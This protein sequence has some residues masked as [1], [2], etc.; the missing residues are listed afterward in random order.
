MEREGIDSQAGAFASI[1]SVVED[2]ELGSPRQEFQ[3]C[4]DALGRLGLGHIPVCIKDGDL[5]GIVDQAEEVHPASREG[6]FVGQLEIQG[7]L[8]ESSTQ[9]KLCGRVSLQSGM[10]LALAVLIEKACGMSL[11]SSQVGQDDLGPH[12]S[13]VFLVKT[14]DIA[15]GIHCRLHSHQTVR[16]KLSR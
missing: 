8:W 15:V 6:Q 9:V 2:G 10:V 11:N 14:F 5:S 1:R 7:Q 3:G 13:I 12:V 16:A 4:P